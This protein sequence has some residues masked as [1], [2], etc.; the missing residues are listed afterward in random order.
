MVIDP[1]NRACDSQKSFLNG[2]HDS[3]CLGVATTLQILI[4]SQ[5]FLKQS[6]PYFEKANQI[7]DKTL[8]K[9]VGIWK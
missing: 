5:L 4:L 9:R 8:H 7:Y 2:H 1:P 6:L 3:Q